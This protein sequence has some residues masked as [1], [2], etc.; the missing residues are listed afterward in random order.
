METAKVTREDVPAAALGLVAVLLLAA[1][2]G[3]GGSPPP[4][5]QTIMVNFAVNA[6][7]GS[8]TDSLPFIIT[9]R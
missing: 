7:S 2:C 5:P 6:T 8:T 9:V 4:Q 3:S 1:G